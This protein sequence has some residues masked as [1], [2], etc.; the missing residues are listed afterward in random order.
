MR[1][2]PGRGKAPEGWGRAYARSPTSM[3][4]AALVI[5]TLAGIIRHHELTAL[6]INY[7]G[8]FSKSFD[9]H[10]THLEANAI[11]MDFV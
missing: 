7:S 1:Y 4:K 6:S 9:E 5:S 10:I 3:G 2:P 11:K 8:V